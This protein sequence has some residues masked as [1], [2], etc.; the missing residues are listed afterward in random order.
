MIVH[1]D[2]AAERSNKR[3]T[4]SE[5]DLVKLPWC[6]DCGNT[7]YTVS[8]LHL[9]W[10]Q[11]WQGH[12]STFN[13][14]TL[15]N[16][17]RSL[18][19]NWWTRTIAI[20]FPVWHPYCKPAFCLNLLL[21]ASEVVKGGQLKTLLACPLRNLYCMMWEAR[22]KSNNVILTLLSDLIQVVQS[23]LLV[24]I[25]SSCILMPGICYGFNEDLTIAWR[26]LRNSLCVV[27]FRC[28]VNIPT[29]RCW[30]VLGVQSSALIPRRHLLQ[31]KAYVKDVSIMLT[32]DLHR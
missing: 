20:Q 4:P 25:M 16:L 31:L 5:K 8:C 10:G 29:C 3:F 27:Y 32:V 26:W 12:D 30:D 24:C 9:S 1:G 22:E 21:V 28:K 14:G 17:W 2:M 13:D 11:L 23:S 6:F 15:G 18:Q 7:P 19:C